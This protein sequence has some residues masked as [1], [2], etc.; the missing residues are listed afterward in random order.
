MILHKISPKS[1][2]IMIKINEMM[3][4][5]YMINMCHLV[6]VLRFG[7][8]GNHNCRIFS[9]PFA[10]NRN[11]RY[12]EFKMCLLLD[13]P[14]SIPDSHFSIQPRCVCVFMLFFFL[15]CNVHSFKI[16]GYLNRSLFEIWCH[17]LFNVSSVES[18]D[19]CRGILSREA[20]ETYAIV[21]G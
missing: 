5:R 17:F 16:I 18:M 15:P 6:V 3:L 10:K 19:K 8:A 7:L 4:H 1:M 9:F 12:G 20:K 21:G 14:I 2:E 13:S 11:S